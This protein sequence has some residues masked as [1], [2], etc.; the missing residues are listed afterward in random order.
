LVA[1]QSLVLLSKNI[2]ESVMLLKNN[3]VPLQSV[4]NGTKF[5]INYLQTAV[6][7]FGGKEKT[8]E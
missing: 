6:Y 5:I 1:N 2:F 4:L 8:T 3:V 7:R